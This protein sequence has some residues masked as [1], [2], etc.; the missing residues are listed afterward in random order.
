[1]AE[2]LAMMFEE[3]ARLDIAFDKFHAAHPEVYVQIVALC[4]EWRGHGRARWAIDDAFSIGWQRHMAGLPA[5]GEK[6]K[7]PN[8]HRSRYSRLVMKREPDL[9]DIFETAAL[10]AQE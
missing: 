6:F 2:Q 10:R 3:R 1:M 4:R 7:L 9:V 8:N 5:D